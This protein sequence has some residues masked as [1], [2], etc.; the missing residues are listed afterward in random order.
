MTHHV[1]IF[2]GGIIGE[3]ET[4]AEAIALAS[5]N[6]QPFNVD[7]YDAEDGPTV[8]GY[9]PDGKGVWIIDPADETA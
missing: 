4:E 7:F 8:Q 9:E 2:G 5:P 1:A 3:A 6:G